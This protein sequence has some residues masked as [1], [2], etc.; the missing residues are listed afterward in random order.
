[1]NITIQSPL[2]NDTTPIN[3]TTSSGNR[4]RSSSKISRE[5]NQE[6]NLTF[7]L[8][9]DDLSTLFKLENIKS[10]IVEEIEE[11]LNQISLKEK[12]TKIS[13]R[14]TNENVNITENINIVESSMKYV[15]AYG[16]ILFSK[17]SRRQSKL[18]K[19]K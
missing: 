9:D 14:M 11:K 5:V 4:S 18:I 15:E 19:F 17:K 8:H 12:L 1:M 3:R 13:P 2:S 7:E 16:D 10:T 6:S